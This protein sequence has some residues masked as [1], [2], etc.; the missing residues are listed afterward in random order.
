[1]IKKFLISNFK[2]L[3]QENFD[4]RLILDAKRLS[5]EN[6]KK[7]KIKDLSEVEFQV[8]SQWGME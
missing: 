3:F 2:K 5:I 1:M 4:K 7:K 6:N 8:F